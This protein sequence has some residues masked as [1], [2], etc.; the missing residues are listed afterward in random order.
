MSL[1][2]TRYSVGTH[3][4]LS[5]FAQPNGLEMRI[6]V[7]TQM[8]WGTVWEIYLRLDIDTDGENGDE[9]R[10]DVETLWLDVDTLR[11]NDSQGRGNVDTSGRDAHTCPSCT[12]ASLS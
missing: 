1:E 4:L 8:H 3:V 11:G 9:H 12:P 2:N 6:W 10:L 5:A 7:I